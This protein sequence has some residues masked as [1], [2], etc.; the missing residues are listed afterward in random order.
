MNPPTLKELSDLK[1]GETGIFFARLAEK[2][3]Q[4]TRDKKAYFVCKF[5][6][7]K[8]TVGA[9]FWADGRLFPYVERDWEVGQ[10]F[11][12][13]ADYVENPR[14]GPQLEVQKIRLVE[15]KDFAEGF[16]PKR[17][18]LIARSDPELAY[19]QLVELVQAEIADPPFQHLVLSILQTHQQLLKVLPGSRHRYYPFP[20]GWLE[21]TLRV[22]QHAALL[23]HRYREIYNELQPPLNVELIVAGAVLHDIGRVLELKPADVPDAP[24]EQTIDGVL[25]G[26]AMLAHDLVRDAARTIENL[27]PERV[28][29]LLHIIASYLKLPEWGSPRLPNIPEV[30]VIH[31]LDD[32]D[33]KMEMY[34]R[35]L[36]KDVSAGPFTERDPNLMALLYRDREV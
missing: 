10:F 4:L 32:L 1:S 5:T 31:H 35:C 26:H 27:H 14:F 24:A 13:V 11:K 30:L 19:Q 18:Q 9:L 22:S 34:C 20:G 23:G 3:R 2:Y 33:A 8:R 7:T 29:L 28:R 25:L 6:D 16:D 15:E 21:H 17:Y 12:I 36:T